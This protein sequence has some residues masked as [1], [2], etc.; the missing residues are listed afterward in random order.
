MRARACGSLEVARS[1]GGTWSLSSASTF[2]RCSGV[3]FAKASACACS[4]VS[5]G[6]VRSM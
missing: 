6:A 2:C 3:S 5:G 4:T 1:A